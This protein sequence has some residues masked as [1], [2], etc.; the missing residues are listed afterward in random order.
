MRADNLGRGALLMLAAAALFA[1]MGALA[2]HAATALPNEM[3]VF[4]RS[5]IGLLVLLPWVARRGLGSLRTARPAAHALRSLV[6]LGSMYC[7]FYALGHLPLAEAVLLNYSAPLFIPFVA[8]LWLGERASAA[9]LGAIALG[10]L[11]IALILK[12]G[13]AIFT[14]VSLI[15]LASG[16]LA[17]VAMGGTRD[18]LKSEPTL[19]I[20]FYYSLVCTL[21]AAPP[22]AWAW[23]APPASLW[24]TLVGVG[25]CA[26]AAHL[27]MTHAYAHAPAAQ[28]GPFAYA[29]IVFASLLGWRFWGEVPDLPALAGAVTVIGAGVLTLRLEGRRA[30]PLS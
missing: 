27:L 17:A 10:F 22:L 18:L 7:F 6:G 11:G 16:I 2:K 26:T 5:L 23:T 3:V 12:P 1:A 30:P 13:A 14:P 19:R 20:V 29:T 24:W 15:A 21:G 9:L 25:G 28:I 8:W 4:F